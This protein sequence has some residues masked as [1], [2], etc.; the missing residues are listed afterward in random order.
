MKNSIL[1]LAREVQAEACWTVAH[2][3]S[4]GCVSILWNSLILR[5]C[6]KDKLGNVGIVAFGAVASFA[7][8]RG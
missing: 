7:C 6:R 8:W 4:G 5:H 2:D 1:P 3:S